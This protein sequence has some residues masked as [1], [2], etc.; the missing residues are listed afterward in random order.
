MGSQIGERV[1]PI[2]LLLA[3]VQVA[4][5]NNYWLVTRHFAGHFA[6]FL[7]GTRLVSAK[8]GRLAPFT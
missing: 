3:C 4:K 2:R 6:N 8:T 1:R 5:D 7:S